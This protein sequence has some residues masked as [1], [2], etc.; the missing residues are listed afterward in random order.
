[1]EWNTVKTVFIQSIG[2][3]PESSFGN[4]LLSETM[5]KFDFFM[6]SLN[7]TSNGL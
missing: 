2:F 6:F 5:R 4:I 3:N 7:S 1:M